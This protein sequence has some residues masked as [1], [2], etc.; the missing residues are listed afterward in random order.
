MQDE[1]RHSVA[2]FPISFPAEKIMSCPAKLCEDGPANSKS[3]VRLRSITMQDEFR[4]SVAVFPISFPAE[5]GV[6]VLKY[7]SVG[8]LAFL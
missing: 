4:H 8:T 7:Y 5:L 2:V 6:K 1:F 3:F